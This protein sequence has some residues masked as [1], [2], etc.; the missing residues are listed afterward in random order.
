[1]SIPRKMR[2]NTEP[3][4]M[5][6]IL[7]LFAHGLGPGAGAVLC[8]AV[9]SDVEAVDEVLVRPVEEVTREVVTGLADEVVT[10]TDVTIVI[11]GRVL[12]VSVGVVILGGAGGDN[13]G[14]GLRE[15]GGVLGAIVEKILLT[16]VLNTTDVDCGISE[17]G[18]G[19]IESWR[20]AKDGL[21]VDVDLSTIVQLSAPDGEPVKALM[22]AIAVV[23]GRY[24]ASEQ[25]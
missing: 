4:A 1:M 5:P 19:A 14:S 6:A 7:P 3:N 10:D 9:G 11:M 12:R 13:V 17:G 21:A 20:T 15:A 2:P 16:D 18:G 22:A 23:I 25:S 8:D 24:M